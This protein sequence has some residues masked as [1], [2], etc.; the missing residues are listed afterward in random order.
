MDFHNR[1]VISI[2]D[3][4]KD[5][6]LHI[7]KI[8]QKIESE[9]FPDL[10]K[11]KVMASAFFEPSTRTRLSFEAAMHRL[12]GSVIGFSEPTTTSL[13][14]GETLSD[15]IKIIDGYCD[16]LV[17]RHPEAGSVHNA[18]EIANN[19]V[20][21]AGDGANEHPTQTFVDL[22]TILKAHGTIENLNIGFLGDLKYGRTVHSLAYALSHFK[23]K[24]YFISNK[25]LRMPEEYLK[26]LASSNV[27]FVEEEDLS[28]V[29]KELD[30]LYVT[31][32]QKERF[33]DANEYEQAKKSYLLDKTL[34]K[35]AKPTL[36]ILHP[37]PRVDEIDPSLDKEPQ[38]IY[39]EQ[40]R[41]GVPVRMALL[42]L[43]LGK[44]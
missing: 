6:L 13:E 14:K 21:N 42:G 31:R 18:A 22:Y 39:F 2:R 10:L 33:L 44:L 28:K 26:E 25:S 29:S 17:M 16:I 9:K 7:L 40:A 8:T 34:L 4:S 12:G 15:T 36:K 20:I 19:P 38:S 43:L 27:T 37:L 32:I 11:G 35:S 5:E 41:N 24:L 30:I 23:N 3:F 1:D